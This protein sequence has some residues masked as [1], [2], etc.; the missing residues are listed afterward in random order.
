MSVAFVT[1]ALPLSYPPYK[2]GDPW[3]V[4]SGGF[5][6]LRRPGVGSK[7]VLHWTNPSVSDWRR[8]GRCRSI[9]PNELHRSTQTIQA[10]RS[11]ESQLA[12]TTKPTLQP[13]GS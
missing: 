2:I 4:T 10:E 8:R 3:T 12:R 7:V 9:G 6:M 5:S 13:H 1:S 11:L